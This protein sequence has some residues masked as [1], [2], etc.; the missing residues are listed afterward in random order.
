M[1]GYH[2]MTLAEPRSRLARTEPPDARL[3]RKLVGE[4]LA[5]CRIEGSGGYQGMCP[6]RLAEARGW[7]AGQTADGA[8]P[9]GSLA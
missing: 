7:A 3:R 5:D 2:P 6:G 1:T 4:F 9:A 8:P